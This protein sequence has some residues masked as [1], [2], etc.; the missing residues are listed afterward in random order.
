MKENYSQ[1]GVSIIA[2]NLATTLI[3]TARTRKLIKIHLMC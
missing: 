2:R 3:Q 1:Q